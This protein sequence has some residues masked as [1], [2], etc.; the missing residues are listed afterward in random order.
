MKANI[1]RLTNA[2]RKAM[3]A[4][5]NRQIAELMKGL[6]DDLCTVILYYMHIHCGHGKKRLHD[7]WKAFQPI[8]DELINRYEIGAEDTPW[9]CRQKLKEIGI[10]TKELAKNC[11][12]LI[13]YE[14]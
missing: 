8:L 7:D 13:D 5:I 14:I 3:V 12:P 10:D 4:E 2:E 9:A 11:K 1:N 6:N